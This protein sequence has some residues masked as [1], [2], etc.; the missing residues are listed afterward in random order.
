MTKNVIFIIGAGAGKEFGDAMPVGSELAQQIENRLDSELNALAEGDYGE[1]SK[2]LMAA[3]AG[4]NHQHEFAMRRIRDGI[5]SKDSIDEFVDE[6]SDIPFLSEVAKLCISDRILY[7]ERK[8]LIF[9]LEGGEG[10]HA[11]HLR[12]L[13]SSWLGL[14][15]RKI[16]PDC[17]RRDVYDCFKGVEFI[18]FNYDRCVE[19]TLYHIFNKTIG[20]DVNLSEK[21]VNDI[22]IHHVYGSLGD[23]WERGSRIIDFGALSHSALSAS[24]GIKTFTE[25]V[26]SKHLNVVRSSVSRAD[27]IVF[28]GFGYHQR[29]MDILFGGEEPLD[30]LVYGTNIGVSNRINGNIAR[31]LER[32]RRERRWQASSCS[33][34][35]TT[36]ADEIFE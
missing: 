14:I 10:D 11:R 3:P 19:R 5:Q 29:N 2:A 36:Y 18:T 27:R 32:N 35:L 31:Y 1:I 22:P 33:E 6:W 30:S 9:P 13:G 20:L 4:F 12:A 28:L 16:N 15:A 7:A 24:R 8:S 21:L 25:E 34:L 23:M 17:R 26:E